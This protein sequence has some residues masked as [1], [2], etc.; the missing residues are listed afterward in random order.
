MEPTK[1]K[2]LFTGVIDE[3]GQKVLFHT[4]FTMLLAEQF[5]HV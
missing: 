3:H 2:V 4:I 1:P 5:H